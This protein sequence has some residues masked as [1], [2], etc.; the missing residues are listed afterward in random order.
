MNL[1]LGSFTSS[2]GEA[3]ALKGDPA[4]SVGNPVAESIEN[5]VM[6]LVAWLAMKTYW[7]EEETTME[8]GRVA[9]PAMP[10]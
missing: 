1:P 10:E 9:V 3:L 2:T 4:T 7:P 8:I 6:L 5:A